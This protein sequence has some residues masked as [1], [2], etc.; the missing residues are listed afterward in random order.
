MKKIAVVI[1][2]ICGMMLLCACNSQN[3]NKI[4]AT[5]L[6]VDK[7][8]KIIETVVEDFSMPQ[9]STE[10]L[11][12]TIAEEVAAYN[13]EVGVDTVTLEHFKVENGIVKT[14]MQFKSAADYEVFNN[15]EFFNG[16]IADALAAGFSLDVIL[17]NAANPDETI[18]IHEI[19]TMQDKRIVITEIPARLR[20]ASKILY[21]SEETTTID[22]YEVDAFENT[23][24]TIIIY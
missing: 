16:T 11:S 17:K 7:E 13:S 12:L 2:G 10:E 24:A 9:Y 18:G 3:P 8:G 1:L 5:T 6:F 21:V 22:E 14:Q 19:L 15:V 23:D 20:V 4:G